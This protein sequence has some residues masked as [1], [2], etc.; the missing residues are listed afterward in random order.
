MIAKD[1][2]HATMI[3]RRQSIHSFLGACR[4]YF[5]ARP[6]QTAV[7]FGAEVRAL[8]AE[9]RIE[10]TAALNQEGYSITN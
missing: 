8:S 2:L 1:H 9:D 6:E 7:Q 4:D 3:D 5:G 10:M